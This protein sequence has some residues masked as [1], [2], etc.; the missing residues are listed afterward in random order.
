MFTIR[1]TTN[2]YAP[3]ETVVL[4]ASGPTAW[5]VDFGGDYDNGA[6]SFELD[7]ADYPNGI[8]FKFVLKPGRWM[9]GANLALAAAE[10]GDPPPYTEPDITFP[11]VSELVTE[12]G[13]VAQ[14]LVAPNFDASHVY[15]VIVVGSGAGGGTLASRL[16]D[17]GRDVLV[18]E[19]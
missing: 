11:A 17:A 10:M 14:R 13:V 9:T 2:T 1:F 12:R 8:E 4:R 6:W 15:D 19:A 16:A 18:L 7:E 5:Q 3:S